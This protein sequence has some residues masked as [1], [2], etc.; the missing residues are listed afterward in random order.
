MDINDDTILISKIHMLLYQSEHHHHHHHHHHPSEQKKNHGG[1]TGDCSCN[2]NDIP[3][4]CT[5]TPPSLLP[6]TPSSQH[7]HEQHLQKGGMLHYYYEE[8][9]VALLLITRIR[10]DD[11]FVRMME[12]IAAPLPPPTA[13]SNN[14]C[15][16][17]LQQ[18]MYDPNQEPTQHHRWIVDRGQRNSGNTDETH[19]SDSMQYL[20]VR[21]ITQLLHRWLLIRSVSPLL[22]SET[23]IPV[24][25]MVDTP[26]QEQV[27]HSIMYHLVQFTFSTTIES[28]SPPPPP[29]SNTVSPNVQENGIVTLPLPPSL[30]VL[31]Q[32]EVLACLHAYLQYCCCCC[33]AHRSTATTTTTTTLA[34]DLLSS[35]DTL[36]EPIWK[37]SMAVFHSNGNDQHTVAGTSSSATAACT[38][39]NPSSTSHTNSH[40]DGTMMIQTMYTLLNQ[41]STIND[42]DINHHTVEDDIGMLSSSSS[43]TIQE[44]ILQFLQEYVVCYMEIQQECLGRHD[45]DTAVTSNIPCHSSICPIPSFVRTMLLSWIQPVKT[46]PIGNKD[47]RWY[48]VMSAQFLCTIFQTYMIHWKNYT[49]SNTPLLILLKENGIAVSDIIQLLLSCIVTIEQDN[50]ITTTNSS[51]NKN[52]QQCI[53]SLRTN[54]WTCV[55]HMIVLYGFNSLLQISS[56]IGVNIATAQQQ[57]QESSDTSSTDSTLGKLS[58]Y[59]V[60]KQLCAI[61]R[62]AAGEY[63]IQLTMIV[64]NESTTQPAPL[65]LTSLCGSTTTRHGEDTTNTA[66]SM[67]HC[68]TTKPASIKQLSI[69]QSSAEIIIATIAC[70][71][72]LAD[73]DMDADSK[74]NIVPNNS[75]D[76]DDGCMEGTEQHSLLKRLSTDAL[77]HI[78]HSIQEAHV[79]TVQYL[80]YTGSSHQ[81]RDSS[82]DGTIHRPVICIFASLL[83]E[84]DIFPIPQLN[85]Q[86]CSSSSSAKNITTTTSTSQ[87]LLALHIALKYAISEIYKDDIEILRLLVSCLMKVL[88][89]AEGEVTCTNLLVEN[90]VIGDTLVSFVDVYFRC[91][92]TGNVNHL[93]SMLD[94]CEFIELSIHME[95][96]CGVIDASSKRRYQTLIIDFAQQQLQ[97]YENVSAS[98]STITL[99]V[100]PSVE[101]IQVLQK[102]FHCYIALQ[103]DTTPSVLHSSIL[104]QILDLIP[105]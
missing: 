38:T 56:S 60:A 28:S 97:R 14:N 50:D 34:K 16:L 75:N 68:R 20:Y 94:V 54:A 55:W 76:D 80:L 18:W 102:M 79:I 78:Q 83:S 77:V 51:S 44:Q 32:L 88:A 95:E 27:L 37:S 64:E 8:Q 57:Q 30:F 11:I 58:R 84:L 74:C 6:P 39:S 46:P 63:K 89:A 69:L 100:K 53:V 26:L 2:P 41:T 96:Q 92:D 43:L 101:M 45:D 86:R 15:I 24:T 71:A 59:G 42:D 21:L 73:D 52:M 99:P 103:G 12:T 19:H 4:A 9:L 87:Q 7:H 82:T 91:I 25:E 3:S 33:M 17:L 48:K 13:F 1:S 10:N 62:L 65:L 90:K 35:I 40:A 104:Q 66:N 23:T 98:T 5:E 47:I 22:P 85:E 61:I 49:K 72:Q 105:G 81:R 93:S 70:M 29:L 67:D 36:I 31:L